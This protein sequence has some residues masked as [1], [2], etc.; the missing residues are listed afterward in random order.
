M[1]RKVPTASFLLS[2]LLPVYFL[3]SCEE[4]NEEIAVIRQEI[5]G[6]QTEL[7]AL[8]TSTNNDNLQSNL[9]PAITSTTQP[10]PSA[11]AIS[12][13]PTSTPALAPTSTQSP[14]SPVSTSNNFPNT[15]PPSPT[16]TAVACLDLSER[17]KYEIDLGKLQRLVDQAYRMGYLF[18]NV[19]YVPPPGNFCITQCDRMWLTDAIEAMETLIEYGPPP[20]RIIRAPESNCPR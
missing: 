3:L 1:V 9:T 7:A 4:D 12:E 20:G 5:A 8:K 14:K 18:S 16:P 2:V 11:T 6:I 13:L 10:T 17:Y 19:I 15:W